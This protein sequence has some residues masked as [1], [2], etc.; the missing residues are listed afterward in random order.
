MDK[1]FV[2][3]MPAQCECGYPT[4]DTYGIYKTR[5]EAMKDLQVLC[6]QSDLNGTDKPR[7]LEKGFDT[8]SLSAPK[9]ARI[10]VLVDE[11]EKVVHIG[12][13][14]A[15]VQETDSPEEDY[16]S[17]S[18]ERH[19]SALVKGGYRHFEFERTL[20]IAVHEDDT[21]ASLA[22]RAEEFVKKEGYDVV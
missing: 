2:I 16:W 3:E 7:L 10:S 8:P 14:F 9:L 13:P 12:R 18:V 5:E 1:V 11:D 17:D 6:Q 22:K 15:S 4:W 20:Y 19:T 21:R